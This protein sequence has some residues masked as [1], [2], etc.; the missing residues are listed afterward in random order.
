MLEPELEG[1]VDSECKEE[2]K[3]LMQKR[4]GCCLYTKDWKGSRMAIQDCDR[5]HARDKATCDFQLHTKMVTDYLRY[6][7]L[8]L[9]D[10]QRR[11]GRKCS[12][13]KRPKQA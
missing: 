5:P 10:E 7:C 8:Q 12:T 9:G 13:P 6:G 2:Y 4:V 11:L 3:Q 1:L